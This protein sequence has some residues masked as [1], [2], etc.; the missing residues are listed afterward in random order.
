M[1]KK[2]EKDFTT[3][4]TTKKLIG[5]TIP[6]LIAFLFNMAYNIVDSVWIGNLLG[7]KAMAALT[8]SMPP[9]LLATSV[10]MG[11]TN[12][13]AIL[14]S[15]NIG[16]KEKN[17]INKVISTS[18]VGAIIFSIM[19]TIICEFG[20]NIILNLL[21]TPDNIYSMAKDYFVIYM[22]G[23]VFVF[24]Y[25]YFTAILRSF[26]NTIMQMISIIL[27]TLLNLVLDPIFI[28]KLGIRGAAFATLFS[29]GIMMGIMV[30]YIIKKKI[31]IIDF[32]LFDKNIIKQI[33][34]N[35]VP[36]II[37]QSIPAIST[38]FITSLVSGFGILPIAAFGISGKLETIL[39]YPAMALNMTIT[40]CTGQCFGAKDTKKAK[41]YL[42]SGMLL[43]SGVL[44]ILT[45]IVV[46]FSKNLA[47][48]F[49]AGESVGKLVKV[50]FSI[51][52]IGYV[53]NTITNCLLGAINGFG[54]PKAAMSLMIFYY[55]IIRMPLAKLLSATMLG[56]NGIWIAIL[57]S[58]IL[59]SIAGFWYFASLLKKSYRNIN[60]IIGM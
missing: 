15:K 34:K 47:S 8:V 19:V 2:L 39:F 38:S 44:I 23:Y 43:G 25:L 33:V 37:Q 29:Q 45:F 9:I 6:L 18:F 50:Y 10:A 26:G 30:I 7:E 48:I 14:L 24:M 52:S 36:S 55:I 28:N 5:I 31:I 59:A 40:T 53:C 42:H 3:G 1:N 13:I 56:V 60:D 4:N 27:C 16:A 46:V 17:S 51:I 58:H 22:L 32:K 35:A 11:A 12:G 21:N 57:V 49:G 20:A 54:K 41:E